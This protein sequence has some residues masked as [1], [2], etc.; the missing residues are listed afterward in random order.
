MNSP[1]DS[2]SSSTQK[3]SNWTDH[4]TSTPQPGL[5]PASPVQTPVSTNPASLSQSLISPQKQSTAEKGTS[6][7]SQP[8]SERRKRGRPPKHKKPHAVPEHQI[9]STSDS[10]PC[11]QREDQMN[12]FTVTQPLSSISPVP[13]DRC[14]PPDAQTEVETQPLSPI[15]PVPEDRCQPPDAQTEVETQPLSP[16]S[17]VP[18]DR[19]QPPDAQTEVETQPLSTSSPVP[20]DRCQPPDAQTEVETQ[21]LSPSSPVPEDRCQPPDAQTEVETQP[22]SPSSPVPEDRCQPPDAQTEVETQPLSPSPPVPEDRCQPPDAQTEVETQPLSPSPPVGASELP[23]PTKDLQKVQHNEGTHLSS[24]SVEQG[25]TTSPNVLTAGEHTDS[26]TSELGAEPLVSPQKQ[27]TAE[28][29][30]SDASQPHSEPRKRGRPPKHKKPHAVPEHQIQSTSDSDPCSQREDQMNAFTVTQHLSSISPVPEDRCQPPDAQTEVET[31]PLS[32]SSPVPEDRCQPPDAQTEVETQPLSPSSPVPEDRCQP[33]DAQTEVETQPLSPSSPVPEDRCQPPDAQTE[34]ETQPLSPSPPVGASELPSPTKDLQKVQHNEG[35]HLS[36]P[37][38]EQGD[39]TSPNVLTAGEHTDSLTSE[40]GAEPLVSPQKQ[41]TAEKGTS[42][43]SKPHSERRKRG[44]PPKHKKPHAVPEHQIQSTSDSDPCSQREDQMNAFTVTQPLSSISPVPEDRCQPPDAQTEV[45][46]QPLSPSPPVG[47]SELPS[48]TKDLQKV[49]HNEGTHLSSPSVEQGDTT[50]PNV[51]TAGEHTDSLTSEL[52]AEPLVSPQKQR[53]AEKG[54]SDAA[55]PQ[56]VRRKR[57]R[58]PKHK[59]PHTVPE[60]QIHQ[61]HSPT[62]T[63]PC[64]QP[65]D[66]TEAETQS[67]T[68][69]SPVPGPEDR[70]LSPVRKRKYTKKSETLK[71]DQSQETDQSQEGSATKRKKES[72]ISLTNKLD[73][74]QGTDP[75]QASE[76]LSKRKHASKTSQTSKVAQSQETVQ[77]QEFVTKRKTV[78]KILPTHKVDQPQETDLSQETYQSKESDKSQETVRKWK[79]TRKSQSHKVGQS[80]ETGRNREKTS[81]KS[82]KRKVESQVETEQSQVETDQSQVETVKNR[83]YTKKSQSRNVVSDVPISLSVLSADLSPSLSS[84][85]HIPPGVPKRK[86]KKITDPQGRL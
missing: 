2:S 56:G 4:Q 73:Q 41:S 24:P 83:K 11:S 84:S 57:G 71:V 20:E 69:N 5:S 51:L 67:L 62:D 79:H 42:D 77:S 38:V 50:S 17:P 46:T 40:L 32:P 54:T 26:L 6:D 70:C 72:K 43:A 86:Y 44:R 59:K 29:G 15:S 65:E 81:E 39:T 78:P 75:S 36:S 23:S 33:P 64:S 82:Q 16:S 55:Q 52:G 76:T 13:E 21:P 28:K 25:D 49:Q 61:A 12:A 1:E 53:T 37:S 45:E 35:T 19:C 18:E 68:P 7:A 66:Q 8:H 48:P 34:V 14:Q 9:Q 80:Q 63:H 60:H 30:T 74:S 27:S 10:D 47:A 22:L 3:T 85:T 58:P 31:Q